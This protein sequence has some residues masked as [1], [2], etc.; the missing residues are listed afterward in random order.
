MKDAIS[1][2]QSGTDGWNLVS[3]RVISTPQEQFSELPRMINGRMLWSDHRSV[4]GT[5]VALLRLNSL[6][7]SLIHKC[8][9]VLMST[10]LKDATCT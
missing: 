6:I 2:L 4:V 3:E 10:S 7:L 9:G 8:Y 5:N 1:L